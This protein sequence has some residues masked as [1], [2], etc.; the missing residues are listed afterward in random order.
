[1]ESNRDDEK[2]EVIE[3]VPMMIDLPKGCPR[4][5]RSLGE[6]VVTPNAWTTGMLRTSRNI[7]KHAA[8][9][10]AMFVGKT[11]C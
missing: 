10:G 9:T 6:I 7:G 2:G 5:A 3:F 8:V 11:R 1:M 4:K